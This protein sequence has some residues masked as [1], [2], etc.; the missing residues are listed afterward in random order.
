MNFDV[1]GLDFSILDCYCIF[2]SP[3]LYSG[4]VCVEFVLRGANDDTR[5]KAEIHQFFFLVLK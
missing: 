3:D 2:F 4:L 5:T 1:H